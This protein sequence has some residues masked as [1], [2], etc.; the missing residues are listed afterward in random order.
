VAFIPVPN[1][2]KVKLT[3][4]INTLVSSISLYF[5]RQSFTYADMET[6]SDNLVL[7]FCPD[8]MDALCDDYKMTQID[9]WDLNSVDG[10]HISN[11]L[12]IDGGSDPGAT[13]VSPAQTCVVSYYAARRGKWNAGRNFVPGL[14]E[15]Q[16]DETDIQGGLA[17]AILAPYLA[18]IEDPPTGWVWVTVSRYLDRQARAV[19]VSSP[20]VSAVVRS[21]RFGFQRRRAA[22]P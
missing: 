6:L 8:L 9:L 10:Y 5:E 2:V 11:G 13:P 14:F 7:G 22:R 17:N 18:L 15:G 16:V 1:V 20:V 3:L 4:T 12:D 19:G 21:N